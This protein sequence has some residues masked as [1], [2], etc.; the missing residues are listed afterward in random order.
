MR[1]PKATYRIQFNS[2]FQFTDAEKI[3]NYLA[4]LGISDIYASPIFK[5]RQGSTHGYDV[6]DPNQINPE[7]GP[8]EA[9]ESLIKKVQ[10]KDLGWVQD[11]VPNHTAYDSENVMLMDVL[12]NGASSDYFDYFDIAWNAPY[13]DISEGVLAPLLGNF[14]QECLENGEIQLQY[15]ATGLTVQYYSLKLPIRIE[16]YVSFLTH[17][18][19]TLRRT[20]GR[21]HPE[22]I[23]LLG[24]L[25]LLKS[26]PAETKGR[27]RY[28][29]LTF[30]KGLLWE[31]YDQNRDI[32]QFIQDNLKEFNGTPGIP[33]SFN[34]LEELLREQVYRL[35]FWKVGAEE[36]NY[37]RFFTVNELIS[38]RVETLRVF[39]DTHHLIT[40]LVKEGKFTGVRIDHI[41]GLYD[42]QQYLQ[43]L[44]EKLGDIY[45]TVEKILEMAEIMPSNWPIQGTS[46]YDFM[47][48][49]N[50]LFCNR[51]N[52]DRFSEI[53]GKFTGLNHSY[54]DLFFEKKH[55]IVDRNMAGDADNLAHLLKSIANQSREGRDFTLYSLK[56]ALVEVLVAFPVYRTYINGE[57]VSSRDRH[58]IQEVIDQAKELLPLQGKELEFIEKLMLLENADYLTE[59][60][61][62][63]RLYSVM[64]IQQWTGPLMAKGIEDTLFYVYNRLVSL[65]EVGGDPAQFGLTLDEFHEF[66]TQQKDSWIHKMNATSTHDTKRGEDVRAR[67]NVLSEIPDEWEQQITS[68]REINQGHKTKLPDK[69]VPTANDEYFF[70]QTLLGA[71]PFAESEYSEFIQRVK[72]CSIKSVREAKLHTA[73]LRPDTAY[74]EGFLAFIDAVM[75]PSPENQFLQK[76]QPFQEKIAAYGV[77]NSLAQVLL[78]LTTPGV[79]DFYQG[80]E[81]WDL[82]L[83]DPDN[84]RPVDF[85]QRI[86][87]LREIRTQ[88]SADILALMKELL[89]HPESGKIK[90]FAIARI[91]EA[92]TQAIELFQTGDYH[93]LKGSGKFSE[94]VVGFARSHGNQV[95]IAIAPRFLTHLIQPDTFPLGQVWQDTHLEL[96]SGLPSQWQDAISGQPIQTD[97]SL[98]IAQTLTHFPIA[99][100]M[101]QPS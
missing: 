73:W 33:E 11:I 45:I 53:Y 37:R 2:K 20:L 64:R 98:S 89:S 82:S 51:N 44:R 65:N 68:W 18:L 10:E 88:A 76:F 70:Y 78:K 94:N 85:E 63:Q 42:P 79:P 50:G 41:D 31:L 59:E 29:Q 36:I 62:E 15:D 84:R 60:E 90:L 23:K 97:G 12:E 75:Q 83:V 56:R 1:I 48:R 55:L 91:L 47:N 52:Q 30:V 34:L 49:L 14:Y 57:G 27:E 8:P 95:A 35:T 87:G 92:R 6:V 7:L 72:D 43:R 80:T 99:L 46:G 54:K 81:L 4:D 21:N 16:S 3:V 93:P 13:G 17:N 39:H 40:K 67:I 66:N 69:V 28:D 24:I 100:L 58:Y 9:F 22:F 19:G 71:F 96:P 5:A 86:T 25:Y 26:I 74:E 61:R 101:S 32:C 77:Y 38:V